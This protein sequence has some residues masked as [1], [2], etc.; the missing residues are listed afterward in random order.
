MRRRPNSAWRRVAAWAGLEKTGGTGSGSGTGGS[1]AGSG[2]SGGTNTTPTTAGNP[3]VNPSTQLGS[4]QAAALQVGG[5]LP[6]ILSQWTHKDRAYSLFVAPLAKVGFYTLTDAGA[7]CVV[8]ATIAGAGGKLVI[9]GGNVVVNQASGS[10]GA[11][12]ATLNMTNLDTFVANASRTWS[13]GHSAVTTTKT[14][15]C[16][17]S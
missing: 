10:A 15:G 11:H 12:I 4:G 2:S 1:G 7:N 13:W 17:R 14:I 16:W 3:T 8:N 6:I 5:Y 9:A